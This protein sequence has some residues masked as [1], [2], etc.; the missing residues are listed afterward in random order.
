VV[1][2]AEHGDGDHG[3]GVVEAVGDAGQESDLGVDRL[4]EAVGHAV[5]DRSQDSGAVAGDALLEFDE[6]GDPAAAGPG[7]PGVQVGFGLLDWELE[8]QPESLFEQ[9]GTVELWFAACDP[10]EFGLL[11]VCEY[12]LGKPS[13]WRVS[14][15]TAVGRVGV[16]GVGS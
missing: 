16:R 14:A 5:L 2:E 12:V 10:G 9:V 6:R 4:D 11:L 7:D 8:D 15:A 1:P 13:M 3:L